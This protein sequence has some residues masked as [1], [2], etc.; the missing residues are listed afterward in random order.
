MPTR[1]FVGVPVFQAEGLTVT[2][3]DM[4]GGGCRVCGSVCVM[5][6]DA[7]APWVVATGVL[8]SF[9]S[10][11]LA[12]LAARWWAW[13]VVRGEGWDKGY[14]LARWGGRPLEEV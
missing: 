2:T 6:R 10:W 5:A 8:P 7:S 11:Y 3:R 9:M 1:Q 13:G 12:G 14:G 4:V